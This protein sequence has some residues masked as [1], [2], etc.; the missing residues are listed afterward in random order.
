MI[1]Q[2]KPRS[3]QLGDSIRWA[4]EPWLLSHAV[5]SVSTA[6]PLAVLAVESRTFSWSPR[7]Y[8]VVVPF[9]A[10]WRLVPT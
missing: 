9:P 8:R 6:G 3:E 4:L 7:G 10:M 2:S 1:V 5:F